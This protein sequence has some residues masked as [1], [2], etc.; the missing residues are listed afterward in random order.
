VD[1]ADVIYFI[2]QR[3]DCRLGRPFECADRENLQRYV[4]LDGNAPSEH[5]R[6]CQLVNAFG[7]IADLMGWQVQTKPVLW[8]RLKTKVDDS[9]GLKIMRT[10][11]YIENC[12][13]YGARRND[14]WRRDVPIPV[15]VY[16][17]APS[18][19]LELKDTPKLVVPVS[20]PPP[21]GAA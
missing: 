2:E 3:F 19:L 18:L 11:V 9:D 4:T 5:H 1:R 17:R 20:D 7:H 13:H 12:P 16:S 8:W 6:A 10:R 15:L 14:H 21:I